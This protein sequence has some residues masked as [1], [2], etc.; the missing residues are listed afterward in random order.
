[1][2]LTGDV[3]LE[4]HVRQCDLI[5]HLLDPLTGPFVEAVPPGPPPLTCASPK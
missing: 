2:V 1:M 3:L 4:I 5:T